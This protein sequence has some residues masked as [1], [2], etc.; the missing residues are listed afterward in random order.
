MIGQHYRVRSIPRNE[1]VPGMVVQ[2][3][4]RIYRASANVESGLY[5]HSLSEKTVIKSEM[6]SVLLNTHGEPL[7]N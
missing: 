5:I 4:D 6:I 1:V 7:T 2:H 3:H